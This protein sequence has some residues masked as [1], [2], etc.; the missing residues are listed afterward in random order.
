MEQL[1]DRPY[2]P[3]VTIDKCAATI[4]SLEALDISLLL[5]HAHYKRTQTARIRTLVDKKIANY[6]AIRFVFLI[7]V[8]NN[9][10]IGRKFTLN[11]AKWKDK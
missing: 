8:K 11:Y 10:L 3:I 6:S 5:C 2:S 7:P 4:S 9:L 1:Y